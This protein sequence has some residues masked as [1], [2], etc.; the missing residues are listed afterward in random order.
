MDLDTDRYFADDGLQE[1]VAAVLTQDQVKYPHP[2]G[3]AWSIYRTEPMLCDRLAEEIAE[4]AGRN[5]LV[6][7]MAASSLSTAEHHVDPDAAGFDSASIP[8]GV[9]EVLDNF[10]D[11]LPESQRPS[12]RALL[13]ALAYARGG[14][15]DDR[16]WR[17]FT[18]ALGYPVTTADLDRLRASIGADYL[19]QTVTDGKEPLTQLFHQA[20]ADELLARR[21]RPSD[22]RALLSA[23]RPE[24]STSWATASAY[25]LTYAA[26]HAS[27]AGQLLSLLDDP[28]YLAYADLTRLPSLL[29][30]ETDTATDPIAVVVR[31]VATRASPLPP[32]RRG[33]LLALAAAQFGLPDMQRRLAAVCDQ[34]FTLIW[35]HSRGIPH[36]ELTDH[37]SGVRAVVIGRIGDRDVIVSGSSDRTV[38]VWDAVTG[39]RRGERLTGHTGSV[40]TVAIGRIGDRDVIVSGSSDSTVRVWDAA[41]GRPRGEPLTGH[42]GGVETVAI[43]RIGDRDVIVSGSWDRTVRV[44][45]AVTGRRRGEPLTGHTGGVNAVAIG[46]IGDRD[47]IVSGSWDSTVR[48][49]DA[50]TGR[51]RGEPL[52][53]HTGTVN[54]VAIRRIGDRDVIVSGSSDSTVRVWDAATGRPRG[55]PLTGHTG[56]VNAV[57]I[58]R[59]GDREVIV[60]GSWDNTVRVW[61]AA[62]GRPRGEPLTGHTGG[63]NAVAIG[64]IGDR[65][66]IVSGCW[67]S[68]V[69][70]WD[71]P[72]ASSAVSR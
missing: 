27:S 20:L 3:A 2:I 14:G 52:T 6:A 58:G 8:S 57:A 72:P 11:Q 43:G 12:T 16:T 46:R 25:A 56:S 38:R 40:E 67:D 26:D 45:D 21:N 28:D 47:V 70:V 59:I 34:P 41:T 5:Y 17:A 13:T 54:A 64:R 62:T 1:F 42:T 49:W 23:L 32:A 55:E 48:V 44:W 69:R 51:P 63:V 50:A 19:V 53:G 15:I 24:P 4:R 39:R 61:D 60:S 35:A 68:T 65:D 33:C 9:G 7:A 30:L 29:S 10:L 66:V 71:P 18:E 31:Q 22:E 37:T 36:M